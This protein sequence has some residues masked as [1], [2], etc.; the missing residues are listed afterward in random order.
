M[1]H[2]PHLVY[3]L[4][5]GSELF[6]PFANH[7]RF[8]PYASRIVAVTEAFKTEIDK[9]TTATGNKD[10]KEWTAESIMEIITRKARTWK[11]EDWM[12]TNEDEQLPLQFRYE[13]ELNCAEF[14][15]PYVWCIVYNYSGM[16]WNAKNIKLFSLRPADQPLSIFEDEVMDVVFDDMEE[17]VIEEH[18]IK[19]DD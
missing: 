3:A 1:G 10:N 17:D 4:L 15:T 6:P 16:I 13:E 11:L 18:Q 12:M 9:T 14:F 7:Q 8:G 5:H 2:N 19:V